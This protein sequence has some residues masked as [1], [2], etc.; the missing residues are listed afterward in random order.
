MT[1]IN[2]FGQVVERGE[3]ESF[4]KGLGDYFVRDPEWGVHVYAA[5]Y[6][7]HVQDFVNL[8]HENQLIFED[9]FID[10]VKSLKANTDDADHFFGNL[11]AIIYWKKNGKLSQI[12][13]LSSGSRGQHE[14]NNYIK[15]IHSSNLSTSEKNP[16]INQ[17]SKYIAAGYSLFEH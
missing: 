11:S 14:I 1:L 5:H 15:E 10:F 17:L 4:F 3:T 16:Y 6:G 7:S 2:L 9:S 12:L 8:R 13:P